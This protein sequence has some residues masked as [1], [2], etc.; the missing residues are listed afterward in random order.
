MFGI[1]KIT[2]TGNVTKDSVIKDGKKGAFTVF[3]VAVNHS[4][5]N[6][7]F[8]DCLYFQPCNLRKGEFIEVWGTCKVEG[9]KD[10]NGVYHKNVKIIVD[11]INQNLP[12][13]N[14]GAK[15]R[16]EQPK[17]RFYDE[18]SSFNFS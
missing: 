2:I 9:F 16:D 8:F 1:S 11:S 18:Q 17:N 5:D 15:N 14:Y 10:N 4:K 7:S 3:T 6:C 12:K 13:E